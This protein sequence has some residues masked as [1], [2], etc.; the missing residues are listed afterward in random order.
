[1][2]GFSIG[3]A[4]GAGFSLIAKRPVS[5]L[6]WGIVYTLLRMGPVA[7]MF[8]LVGPDLLA[9]LSD[10]IKAFIM[11]D[12]PDDFTRHIFPAIAKLQALTALGW[13][14]AIVAVGIVHAAIFRAVLRPGDGGFF[15]MKLGM[16]EVW[17]GLVFLCAVILIAIL[18]VGVLMAGALAAMLV[19]F[20]G[21]AVGS[22]LGGWI[23]GI[24][25]V[26]VW[27]SAIVGIIW[28]CLR[29]SLAGPATFDSRSFQLFESWQATKG[30]SWPL[31]GLALLLFVTLLAIQMV[32]GV[33]LLGAV[34]GLSYSDALTPEAIED[35][36]AQPP[37]AWVLQASPFIIGMVLISALLGGAIYTILL[38]PFASAYRQITGDH[39]TA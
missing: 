8:A 17:Q 13:L 10:I 11:G 23:Q 19:F 28:I 30:Q 25:M 22:P 5:V 33:I 24:G 31:L 15:N 37:S 35:F 4:Y 14:T 18:A 9:G 32:L 6:M 38:A 20:L 1:M 16:D 3:E 26:A 27:I 2:N 34:G 7:L 36:F 39:A 12:D 29:F 21:E